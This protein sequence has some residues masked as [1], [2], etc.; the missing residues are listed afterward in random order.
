M[1][2]AL[3]LLSVLFLLLAHLTNVFAQSDAGK[4]TN[5]GIVINPQKYV[6]VDE[7]PGTIY[8]GP[9]YHTYTNNEVREV[10]DLIT[11]F[12]AS[13]IPVPLTKSTLFNWLFNKLS[14]WANDAIHP[15]YVGSWVTRA[16]D[17]YDSNLYNYYVT[18]V[19]YQDSTYNTPL[20]V[21][22]YLTAT[23]RKR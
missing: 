2:K 3:G 18:V 12:A 21:Q 7:F 23:E 1:K 13:K 19:Y 20:E 11:A 8:A 16:T 5:E 10:V 14:G 6:P 15:T 9:T 4:Y 17:P 22:Y